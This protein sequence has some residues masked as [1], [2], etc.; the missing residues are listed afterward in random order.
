MFDRFDSLHEGLVGLVGRGWLAGL[1]EGAKYEAPKKG[2]KVV[3]SL[4]GLDMPDISKVKKKLACLL[5]VAK[6]TPGRRLFF[7]CLKFLSE[8]AFFVLFAFF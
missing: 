2:G 8:W 1:T 4:E 3:V 6:D 5:R 7:T